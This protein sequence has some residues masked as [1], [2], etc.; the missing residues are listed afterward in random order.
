MV[1]S[2]WSYPLSHDSSCKYPS[3]LFLSHSQHTLLDQE[4]ESTRSIV[5]GVVQQVR[6]FGEEI[7]ESA[8]R[9]SDV[10]QQIEGGVGIVED[11]DGVAEPRHVSKFHDLCFDLSLVLFFCTPWHRNKHCH[12]LAYLKCYTLV[13]VGLNLYWN[14]NKFRGNICAFHIEFDVLSKQNSYKYL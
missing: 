3:F 7:T 2:P 14:R 11:L 12:I 6:V 8:R 9:L 5:V 4:A 10:I 13:T 1:E